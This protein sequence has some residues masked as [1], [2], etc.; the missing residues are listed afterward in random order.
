MKKLNWNYDVKVK[1]TPHGKDIFYHQFDNLIAAGININRKYPEED[2]D[3]FVRMQLW[4]FMQLYGPHIAMHL[5]NI[6][7]DLSFYIDEENLQSVDL[8]PCPHCQKIWLFASDGDYYSDYEK[9][10]YRV[11]CACGYAWEVISWQKT[12]LDA[13][14]AWNKK[15]G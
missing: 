10:G 5:P 15:V 6:V 14:N 4:E 11:N 9:E 12:K 13:I 8:K 7:E 2:K 1:L 3:G